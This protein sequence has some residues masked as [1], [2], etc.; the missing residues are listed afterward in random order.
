MVR[1]TTRFH[2]RNKEG[3][4]RPLHQRFDRGKSRNRRARR[5]IEMLTV[6]DESG[7]ASRKRVPI[8]HVK[9]PLP[10][11]RKHAAMTS[12]QIGNL[13]D[14]VANCRASGSFESRSRIQSEIRID[15]A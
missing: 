12:S 7:P 1:G 9:S 3:R 15:E 10:D 2:C 14:I 8:I 6:F 4:S 13:L 11:A 5:H